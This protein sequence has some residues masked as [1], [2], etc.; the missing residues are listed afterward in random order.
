MVGN[1]PVEGLTPDAEGYYTVV[2]AVPGVP[3]VSGRIY[4][5]KQ[6]FE[7][8]R[9]RQAQGP[10]YVEF[11]NPDVAGVSTEEMY[12]RTTTVKEDRICGVISEGYTTDKRI[13]GKFKPTGP[14]ADLVHALLSNPEAELHF[15]M[16]SLVWNDRFP[17]VSVQNLITF[18]LVAPAPKEVP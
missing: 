17:Y 18:D 5:P 9:A 11:G 8:Y 10:L 2:L 7:H 14:K 1:N 4:D 6:V 12:Y 15:G 13:V 16:R 3:S